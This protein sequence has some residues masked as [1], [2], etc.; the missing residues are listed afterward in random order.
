VLFGR[1]ILPLTPIW[2]PEEAIVL[3]PPLV[4]A[5][6]REEEGCQDL[7]VREALWQFELMDRRSLRDIR[8]FASEVRLTTQHLSDMDDWEIAQL[9][10]TAIKT[11]DLVALRKGDKTDQPGDATAEQRRLVGNID[12]QTRGR[13]NFAGRLYRLVTD[14][15]LARVPGRDS[16]EVVGRDD[17][18][19]VL[20]GLAKQSGTEGDLVALLGQASAKL[21]PDWR[22]PFQPSGLILLR[23]IA[24][25]SATI[26]DQG[27]AVS[28]SQMRKTMLTWIAVEFVDDDDE[29]W[30]GA[31][32]ITL[33]DGSPRSVQLSSEGVISLEEIPPGKVT[34]KFPGMTTDADT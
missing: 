31:V 28:P 23:R 17:A 9:V 12:K 10:R 6:L 16:Y 2:E 22:P 8:R 15:D 7:P 4:A 18:Q 30:D 5:S 21:T 32:D 24:V 19:R 34:V 14:V 1:A 11:G 25:A 13:L 29:P 26:V 20:D 33:A 3:V 27:P